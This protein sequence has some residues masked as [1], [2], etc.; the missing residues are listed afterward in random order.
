MNVWGF[1]SR[2]GGSVVGAGVSR[3]LTCCRRSRR[4]NAPTLYLVLAALILQAFAS[5]ANGWQASLGGPATFDNPPLNY[6]GPDPTAGYFLAPRTATL[7]PIET[8]TA[9]PPTAYETILPADPG[10][11]EWFDPDSAI[12]DPWAVACQISAGVTD[13]KDGFFQK[14]S[15]TETWI[16]RA[17]AGDYGQHEIDTY[18][19]FAVPAPTREWPMLISPTFNLRLLDGPVAPDLPAQLY[20]AYVD[21]LWLPRLSPRWTGIVGV[22]PSYYSDFEVDS[23]KAFRWTGKGLVRYDWIPNRLQVLAGVLYLNRDDI[24]LLPAG[25]FIWTPSDSRHYELLFPKPKLAHRIK[26]GDNFEDWVYVGGEFGG[27]SYA[28]ERVSGAEDVITLRDIRAYIGLERKKN[29]GAGHFLEIGYV[30][31]RRVEYSSATPDIH[32][33]DAFLLR[34][35][36][37]F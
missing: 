30:F 3:R 18:V 12:D 6:E 29:G 5:A 1:D 26:L 13:H 31:S 28:I 32:A 36:V 33:D 9:S 11:G 20:E 22:A 21:F 16:D 7:T 25:G 8:T 23:D 14:L 19:M 37:R 35:G 2:S 34:G 10:P 27:N 4:H 15:F 17:R 24:R